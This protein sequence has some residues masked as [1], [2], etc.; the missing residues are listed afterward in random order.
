MADLPGSKFVTSPITLRDLISYTYRGSFRDRWLEPLERGEQHVIRVEDVTVWKVRYVKGVPERNKVHTFRVQVF[1]YKG[2]KTVNYQTTILLDR[3]TLDAPVKIRCGSLSKY[4]KN[5]HR[6]QMKKKG[7]CG[8]FY[9]RYMEVHAKRGSLYQRSSTNR[10]PPKVMNPKGELGL[11]K[12]L[13]SAIKL[14]V[15]TNF[16]QRV[17]DETLSLDNQKFMRQ[18]S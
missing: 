2:G 5:M 9:F 6:D 14:M 7:I 13:V 11:C 18:F 4:T 12:H 3:L 10:Q 17:D 16:F 8:D 15:K 1:N